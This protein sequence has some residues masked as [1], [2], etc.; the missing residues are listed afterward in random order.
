VTIV[1]ALIFLMGFSLVELELSSYFLTIN[2][3]LWLLRGPF[4]RWDEEMLLFLMLS[5]LWYVNYSWGKSS[6]G[7]GN[8]QTQR[9]ERC[10]K[11][12]NCSILG[13]NKLLEIH[14]NALSSIIAR[15]SSTER[16]LLRSF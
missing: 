3:P 12:S 14:I 7:V 9:F 13:R 11:A 5:R 2:Y 15:I 6:L 10:S 4:V 16:I 1:A 8:G